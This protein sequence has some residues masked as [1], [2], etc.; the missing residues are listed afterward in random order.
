L[1]NIKRIIAVITVLVWMIVIFIF[2]AM[3][4]EESNSKSQRT[5]NSVIEK[6]L[7]ITNDLGITDKHPSE[8]KMKQVIEKLNKPLRKVAHASEYCVL[9]I[10]IYLCLK[11]CKIKNYKSIIISIVLAFIYACTDE[12]H[13]LFVNGR[14]GR[15][16]DVLID[17]MGAVIGIIIIYIITKIINKIKNNQ[18]IKTAQNT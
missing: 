2:S 10:F 8:G 1:K 6:I 15:F 18:E 7:E 17:T 5:I 16:T 12:F 3:P 4:S 13:Q 9:G 14:T 11:A